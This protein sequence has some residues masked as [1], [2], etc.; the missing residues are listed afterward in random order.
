[1]AGRVCDMV[2]SVRCVRTCGRGSGA[3]HGARGEEEAVPSA[4]VRACAGVQ[5]RRAACARACG[6]S[7]PAGQA[8]V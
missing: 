7:V 8:R 4:G 6:V 2:R 5:C 1:M 3:R